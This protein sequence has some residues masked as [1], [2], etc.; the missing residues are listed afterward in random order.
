MAGAFRIAG[1]FGTAIR[2]CAN[3]FGETATRWSIANSAT[4]SI[5]SARWRA[6]WIDGIHL[7]RW[8][9]DR[10]TTNEWIT[11]VT[12]RTT[13]YGIMINYATFSCDT[14][15]AWTWISALL[16]WTSFVLLAVRADNAFWSTRWWASNIARY[17]GTHCLAVDLSAL[18]ILSARR[19]V[20]WILWFNSYTRNIVLLYLFDV[21]MVYILES[22]IWIN[23]CWRYSWYK[24]LQKIINE[25]RIK[26]ISI[27][28]DE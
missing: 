23:Q 16:I 24:I 25:E 11:R 17:T 15:C 6:T 19:R 12:R 20:T 26:E 5:W 3:E 8:L 10:L 27:H 4:F 7:L 9:N 2:W 22:F 1:T 13:A 28:F 21:V 18:T 14:T